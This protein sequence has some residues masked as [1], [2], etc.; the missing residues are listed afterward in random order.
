[1]IALAPLVGTAKVVSAP[2]EAVPLGLQIE[3][4]VTMPSRFLS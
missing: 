3:G 2:A 4:D 1:M